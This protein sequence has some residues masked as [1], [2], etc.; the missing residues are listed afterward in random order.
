MKK[1]Y[2]D[3]DGV[4]LTAKETRAADDV[5]PFIDY[6]LGNF[7]CYW[8]TTHCKGN[9]G[10]VL[11]HLSNYFDQEIIEQLRVIKP[12]AWNTLKT[13][14]I[15]F[16][17]DFYWLDDNPM[18]FEVGIIKARSLSERLITVNLDREDELKEIMSRLII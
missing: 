12:T 10:P 14:A 13:E 11:N 8:L 7:D 9:T 15:D 3:V 5:L 17:S 6:I 4:L 2:L 1:L 16:L 18:Q